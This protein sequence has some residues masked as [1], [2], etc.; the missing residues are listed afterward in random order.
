MQN[1]I[2][3]KIYNSKL[4]FSVVHT[5]DVNITYIYYLRVI[6]QHIEP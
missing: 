2:I 1:E 4:G 3:V 6:F 5:V